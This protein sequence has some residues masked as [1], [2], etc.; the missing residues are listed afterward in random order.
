VERLP[1]IRA[2]DADRDQAAVRLRHATAEGRLSADE[3]EDRLE[4]LF[5]ARTYGE[6]DALLADLPVSRSPNGSPVRVAGWVGAAAAVMVVLAVLGMVAVA[7]RHYAAAVAGARL[8][9][10]RV[11]APLVDPHHAAVAAASVL[12]VFAVLVACAALAFA[13]MRSR[14][15][16][17]I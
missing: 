9:Q 3:L 1:S 2:S 12:G 14:A 6:V 16:S 4:A 11:P 8:R 7:R 5:A 17:K 10:L 15:S 13:L